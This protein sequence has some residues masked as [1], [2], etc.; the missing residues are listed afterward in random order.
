MTS[1]DSSKVFSPSHYTDGGIETIEKIRAVVRNMTPFDAYCVG[2][3]IKYIDRAGKKENESAEEDLAKAA[4][5]L[6]MAI[7][8]TWLDK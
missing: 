2:N 4:N 1:S 3:V 8:R 5:Y 7:Y 6:H